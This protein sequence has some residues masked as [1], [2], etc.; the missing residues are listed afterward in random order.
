MA[1]SKQIQQY[2]K[3]IELFQP[4]RGFLNKGFKAFC[5]GGLIC[6]AGQWISN[7]YLSSLAIN[8]IEARSLML[9][10]IIVITALLTGLGI[11]DRFGQ[12][13]GAGTLVPVTGFTNAMTS[14][15]LEYRSEGL[16]YGVGAHMFKLTGA[17]IAFGVLA[18]YIVGL[19]RLLIQFIIN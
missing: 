16:V 12:Y 17:I 9:S 13:A 8:E 19:I 15:A 1:N 10:T 7:F 4:K 3:N 6:M 11:F 18:S 14:A 5:I 2:H